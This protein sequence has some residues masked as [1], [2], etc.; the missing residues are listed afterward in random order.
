MNP[1][2]A[3]S[4]F[5]RFDLRTTDAD[6][7][8]AFYARV[9]GHDQSTI[10]PLHEQAL[11]RGARPH[12]LGQI[13][14]EDVERAAA[15]F[16]ERGAVPLGPTRPTSDGGQVA[17]LRDP[18][19]AVVAV[20]T[21]PPKPASDSVR[22]H[23]LN[24][25]DAALAVKN[26]S[27]LFGWAMS[28]SVDLGAQGVFQSFAWGPGEANAGAI[29][30]V[31]S[32]PGVHPHWLFFFNVEKLDASITA[33]RTAGGRLLEPI[34]LPNGDRICVCDDPQGAAFG[35]REPRLSA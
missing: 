28:E 19:G 3:M 2:L 23:V 16:M 25:N 30:D 21:P 27:E 15:A 1:R 34:V 14:V 33:A 12:W 11:A 29:S 9:L 32:R 35:L 31:A 7:A 22:F 5:C 4:R 20:S 10:W 18:G 17:V 13:G 24:T 8:R 6:G 26:Y